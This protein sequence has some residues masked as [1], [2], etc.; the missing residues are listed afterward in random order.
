MECAAK[1][2]ILSPSRN[3]NYGLNNISN[4]SLASLSKFDELTLPLLSLPLPLPLSVSLPLSS[5]PSP[6]P[7]PIS[8][9]QSV[10]PH[11]NSDC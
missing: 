8:E 4:D 10:P 3:M 11:F 7:G 6:Y 9:G 2:V 5:F 1:E